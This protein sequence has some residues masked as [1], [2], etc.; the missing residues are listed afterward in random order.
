VPKV[1]VDF[2]GDAAGWWGR[3]GNSISLHPRLEGPL[4]TPCPAV[5]GPGAF[6]KRSASGGRG[7]VLLA[8]GS[9]W[10]YLLI[11]GE[12]HMIVSK[13]KPVSSGQPPWGLACPPDRSGRPNAP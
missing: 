7:L 4:W 5:Y 9:R 11:L 3:D 10:S 13:S 2:L 8:S 12:Y 1:T 6:L